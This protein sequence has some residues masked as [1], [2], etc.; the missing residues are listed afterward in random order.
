MTPK[1]I[2]D[3]ENGR[4]NPRM[5]SLFRLVLEL[6]LE[7]PEKPLPREVLQ[8]LLTHETFAF[9]RTIF[10]RS[11]KAL[12]D[13]ERVRRFKTTQAFDASPEDVALEEELALVEGP[14]QLARSKQLFAASGYTTIDLAELSGVSVHRVRQLFSRNGPAVEDLTLGTFLR[15]A[16]AL[17]PAG[18]GGPEETA[19][20]LLEDDLADLERVYYQRLAARQQ[21]PRG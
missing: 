21:E 9:T 4:G 16:A 3:L 14:V 7:L 20:E 8:E 15:L 13:P 6:S 2:F 5:S 1:V 19:Y 11:Q 18:E 12:H 17:A 10:E